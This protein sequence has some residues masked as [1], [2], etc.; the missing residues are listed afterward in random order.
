MTNLGDYKKTLEL[1]A[2]EEIEKGLKKRSLVLG[3]I[4]ITSAAILE[5][6]LLNED[7]TILEI[8]NAYAYNVTLMPY[9]QPFLEACS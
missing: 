2:E 7:V 6:S 3:I 1:H 8:L 5:L 4:F 9:M